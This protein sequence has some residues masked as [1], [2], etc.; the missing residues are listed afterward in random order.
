MDHGLQ[1]LARIPQAFLSPAPLGYILDRAVDRICQRIP[2]M[3]QA[4][5]KAEDG[6]IFCR[7]GSIYL[8]KE[9]FS[10]AAEANRKGLSKGGL[11]RPDQCRL[12]LGMA[13]FNLERYDAARDAFEAAARDDRSKEYAEQWMKY[14]DNEIARQEE[15]AK[16]LA[17]L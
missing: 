4:A 16:D 2:V 10:K 11:K 8:D 7:L 14:M 15:L 9:E 13:Y 17:A 5:T 1:G 6:E 12:V 3:E